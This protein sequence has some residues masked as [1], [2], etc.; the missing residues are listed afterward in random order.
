VT[1]DEFLEEVVVACRRV[2]GVRAVALGGSRAVGEERPDSDWDFAVYYEGTIDPGVFETLGWTGHVY[3]P[4]EWG[5]VTYGGA[6]FDLEDRHFDIHYRNLDVVDHWCGEAERGRFEVHILGF[7][8]AGIPTYMLMGELA[9][10]HWLWGQLTR[11]AYPAALAHTAPRFW[12]D[13]AQHELDYAHYWAKSENP[14][15]CAGAL[16]KVTMQTAHARLA[17]RRIW[18][19]NEKRLI[20]LAELSELGPRFAA[21]GSGTDQLEVAIGQVEHVIREVRTEICEDHRP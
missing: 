4:F 13:R 7:H 11:P 8:L 10:N 19:L 5:Q 16:A 6:V 21:L 18:A 14:V 15:A 12:L 3:R 20:E 2:P 9:T 1:D 17:H